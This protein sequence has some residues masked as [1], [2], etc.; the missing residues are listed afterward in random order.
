MDQIGC[1]FSINFLFLKPIILYRVC[2]KSGIGSITLLE[3]IGRLKSN[4]VQWSK[5][6]LRI[7]ARCLVYLEIEQL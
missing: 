4:W 6:I 1:L 2:I 3:F 7:I 5:K